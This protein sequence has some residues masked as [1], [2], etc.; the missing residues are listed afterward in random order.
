MTTVLGLADP[1]AFSCDSWHR[2][3]QGLKES[4]GPLEQGAGWGALVLGMQDTGTIPLGKHAA[5]APLP[6]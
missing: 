6:A 3:H 5:F 2:D 1:A 4:R